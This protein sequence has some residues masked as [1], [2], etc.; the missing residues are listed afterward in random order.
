M[1]DSVALMGQSGHGDASATPA[2]LVGKEKKFITTSPSHPV[3]CLDVR[4]TQVR[5][6]RDKKQAQARRSIP[7]SEKGEGPC[8]TP[9]PACECEARG[10]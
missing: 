3:T 2:R 6:Q 1:T 4:L 7:Q 10:G 8:Q 5:A 9:A